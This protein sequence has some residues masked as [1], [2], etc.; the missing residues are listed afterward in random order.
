MRQLQQ[1][2]EL[3][4]YNKSIITKIEKARLIKERVIL[5]TILDAT[6]AS[7]NKVSNKFF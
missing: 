7:R 6:I 3:L 4:N 2:K 1:N 5:V